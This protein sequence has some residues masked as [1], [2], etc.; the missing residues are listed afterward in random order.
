MPITLMVV[1]AS[2]VLAYVQKLIKSYT[3]NMCSSLYTNYTSI[4]LLKIYFI[5]VKVFG[6][7]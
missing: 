7:F 3:F 4:K 6:I 2:Q 1:M 5:N